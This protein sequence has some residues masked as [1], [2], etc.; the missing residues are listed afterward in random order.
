MHDNYPITENSFDGV[1]GEVHTSEMIFEAKKH[2]GDYHDNM[3]GEM[4]QKW[5]EERFVPTFKSKYPGK[6]CTHLEMISS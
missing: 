1:S 4:F 3:D 6:K 5:L 2:R